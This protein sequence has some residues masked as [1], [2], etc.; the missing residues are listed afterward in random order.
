MAKSQSR[1][2]TFWLASALVCGMAVVFGAQTASARDDSRSFTCSEAQAFV[3][4]KRAV[5]MA[6]STFLYYRFVASQ[7]E[8]PRGQAARPAAAP[9]RDDPRCNVGFRCSG[10]VGAER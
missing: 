6:T 3:K 5:V 1:D 9:T 8:C 2:P 10:G 4:A 7:A